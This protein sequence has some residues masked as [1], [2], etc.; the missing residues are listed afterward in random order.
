MTTIAYK[1][2]VIAADSQATDVNEVCK[3]RKLFKCRDEIVSICGDAIA[4]MKF[5]EW[6]KA[7][8]QEDDKPKFGASDDFLS[9][10]VTSNGVALWDKRMTPLPIKDRFSALGSGSG[11]ALGAMHMGASAREAIK[12]AIRWDAFTG[13]R[14]ISYSVKDLGTKRR[15]RRSI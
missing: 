14:V 6:R 10:V 4:A 9:L 5:V 13:G 8:A 1:D 7:G 2:G 15:R 12:A 11:I 3:V